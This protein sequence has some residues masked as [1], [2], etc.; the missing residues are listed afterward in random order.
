MPIKISE[1]C[2]WH[3]YRRQ[4]ETATV[5]CK[6]GKAFT[7]LKWHLSHEKDATNSRGIPF[8]MDQNMW[9]QGHGQLNCIKQYVK[10]LCK[11]IVKAYVTAN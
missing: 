1:I 7:K 10:R 8:K 5:A 4:S 2:N 11:H 9:N 6:F 3:V